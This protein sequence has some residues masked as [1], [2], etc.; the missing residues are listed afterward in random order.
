MGEWKYQQHPS[1]GYINNGRKKHETFA[2]LFLFL[3]IVL[4]VVVAALG[5]GERGG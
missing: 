2:A 3:Q 4:N 1:P 5:R